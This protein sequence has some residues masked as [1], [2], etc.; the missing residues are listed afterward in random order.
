MRAF[1]L[2]NVFMNHCPYCGENPINHQ[3]NKFFVSMDIWFTPLRR[4][5]FFGP[6]DNYFVNPMAD[7]LAFA[8]YQT[9]KALKLI[10]FNRDIT[11]IPYQRAKTLWQEAI[12]QGIEFAEIKPFGLSIDCYQTKIRGKQKIFFGLPRPENVDESILDWIDDKWI[13]KQKL[14]QANLP[15]PNGGSF[16]DLNRALAFFQI[17]PK[18][19]V[20]KPRKGSRGRH[21]TTLVQTT[22]QLIQA[23]AI[24]KQLCHYIVIEEYLAGD[25]YRGTVIDSKLVGIL[26][27]SS[28][29]VTGDGVS[30]IASLVEQHNQNLPAGMQPVKITE[31]NLRHLLRQNLSLDSVLPPN[32]T[33]TLSEKIGVAYGGTSFDCTEVAHPKT[34]QMFLDAAAAVSDPILGFDFIAEDI[35]KSPQEQAC[36]IIECNGAPFI[37]LHYDPLYGQ[38]INAA[39]HVWDLL[40]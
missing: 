23:F 30:T 20:V 39:K 28:P 25:V 21:T 19:V 7:G 37:N 24:A 4:K 27:G 36:G 31:S 14:I 32:K 13:L 34:K 40:I 22:E 2:Y 9:L 11:K 29:K 12:N 35:R 10:R 38:T 3:A 5:L 15:V 6:I 26:G 16:T 8:I 1:L 33:V 17:L 18:P